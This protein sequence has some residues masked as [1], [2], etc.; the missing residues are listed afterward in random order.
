VNLTALRVGARFM[1]I[2]KPKL[3]DRA[4][5]ILDYAQGRRVLHVGMGGL[6]DDPEVTRAFIEKGLVD[7]LHARLAKCA[8]ALT[9]ID[10]NQN[11]LDAMAREVP[12]EYYRC[13][14]S[15]NR[16]VREIL[17]GRQ[18]ELIL[19][20][21]VIEHLDDFRTA[22]ANLKMLLTSDGILLIST[23]N[24]YCFEAIVK[25]LFRHESVNPEHTCYF[26]YGTL[27][28]LLAMNGLEIHE[29]MFYTIAD[30]RWFGSWAHRV[31]YYVSKT[32]VRLFPQYALGVIAVARPLEIQ[33]DWLSAA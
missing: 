6:V 14:V 27:S 29:F 22:L 5:A 28:R 18:Y 24:A 1:F 9:G 15:S 20:A 8:A 2:P 33:P 31:S 17:G 11:V 25:L 23:V 30:L 19:F 13:D 32:V 7:S 26:S 10:V 21:D 3:V 12:G 4:T 16:D